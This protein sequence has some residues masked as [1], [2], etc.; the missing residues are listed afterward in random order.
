MYSWSQNRTIFRWLQ[1]L[2][3]VTYERRL[4]KLFSFIWSKTGITCQSPHQTFFATFFTFRLKFTIYMPSTNTF[5]ICCIFGW[6]LGQPVN[7]TKLLRHNIC[8][9]YL[10]C[11]IVHLWTSAYIWHLRTQ[12]HVAWYGY[13]C[14]K[15]LLHAY[16]P[17]KRLHS[18]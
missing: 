11:F 13:Q 5:L 6:H 14:K 9:R 18:Q 15:I 7:N 1:L 17:E 3:M 16:W 2:H 8:R 4:I 12:T 10:T